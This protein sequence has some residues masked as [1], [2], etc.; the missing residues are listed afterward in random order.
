MAASIKW[1]FICSP[2]GKTG[3]PITSRFFGPG[4]KKKELTGF[5]PATF[6]LEGKSDN[7]ATP[8]FRRLRV[9]LN[10]ESIG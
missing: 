4:A 1:P 5:E 9:E 8:Q 10:H 2:E 7:P 6:S 3:S